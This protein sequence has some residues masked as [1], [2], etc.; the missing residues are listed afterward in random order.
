[1][2][3]LEELHLLSG[4]YA[5]NA[6]DATDT[7]RYE[8][9][10]RS[11]KEARMEV[12]RL[13]ETATM[14]DLASLP[15]A[16]PD[17]LKTRLMAQIAV[18]PQIGTTRPV[19]S[20]QTHS[21]GSVVNADPVRDAARKSHSTLGASKAESRAAARWYTK[22]AAILIAVAAAV[23]LFVSGQLLGLAGG[24]NPPVETSAMVKILS[25]SDSQQ[26]RADVTG[27]GRATFVWSAELGKSVVLIDKLPALASGK[28]YELWYI[29]TAGATAAGTFNA[30][31]SGKTVRV[32]DGT[33]N[34][35]ET[36]GIT[37][38]PSGGSV[39]PTS[40][41]IVVIASA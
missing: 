15:I 25:A 8:E 16:P 28:T 23:A 34:G 9:Y 22:P 41:P 5:L 30:A 38:E 10:L 24:N 40:Q 19:A 1:M 2:T 29:T 31:K 39:K 18:T 32:L 6:L 4:A 13:R 33:M 20:S 7:A 3:D 12:A 27:G 36:F 35:G 21:V 37:V 26:V 14:I 17:D 11:S